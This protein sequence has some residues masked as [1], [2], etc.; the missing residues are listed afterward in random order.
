MSRIHI[1]LGL[2][3]TL[4]L[5]GHGCESP[6]S[7]N[8]PVAC[9]PENY[10][11]LR[12][13]VQEAYAGPPGTPGS[14]ALAMDSPEISGWAG[15][16]VEPVQFG[17]NLDDEWRDAT[18]ALGP[19]EGQPGS[20]VA[21]GRGGSI[22]LTFSPPITDGD[23]ADFAV[24]ENGLNDAFLELAFIEVSSD[25]ETFVRFPAVYLGT[26][27]VSAYA[28]HDT[29]LIGGLAGKYR[30]G[31]GTSFD[32]ADVET[33][34]EVLC[35]AVDTDDIGFVRVVDV[36]GDGGTTD[37]AGNPIYDPYPTTGSAGFDLDAVA[38]LNAAE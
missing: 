36:V 13:A 21:L 16:F 2:L 37:S 29:T 35:G 23:G 34:P 12:T 30:G 3:A 24:F 1:S 17:P 18:Q 26:V 8:E 4:L 28:G 25:G 5:A 19:A 7:G 15:A 9:A 27:P 11:S 10:G 32:L 22:I 31:F 14:T 38:V 33:A 6:E 20:I